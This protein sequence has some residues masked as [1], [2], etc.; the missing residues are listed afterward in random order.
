MSDTLNE[1]EANVE[2]LAIE[3]P[4]DDR[5][6]DAESGSM[7]PP[8]SL[9]SAAASPD[10]IRFV[11][12]TYKDDL[13]GYRQ[14]ILGRKPNPATVELERS[15]VENKRT[16]AG[17]GHGIGKTA[18][19]ADA[20][21]WF[22]STRPHPAIVATANTEDQLEKK[23]WRELNKTN[24]SAKNRD[25]FEWK[26]KT[27]T[28]FNDPTAQAV[29][30]TW[31]ETNPEA[32][33]GTH[34]QHVLGVFDEASAI[35]RSIFNSFAGAMTT[36]G[37][38][39]LLLGNSTRNEGYF[40]DAVHGKLKARKPGDTAAR[41]VEFVRHPVDCF[42]V[43]RSGVGRRDEAHARRGQRRVPD[44]RSRASAAHRRSAVHPARHGHGAMGRTSTCSTA[45][46]SCSAATSAAAIGRSSCRA[47]AARCWTAFR[48]CT[49]SGRWTSLSASRTKSG[50]T[51]TS[52]T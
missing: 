34:E 52:T 7:P 8:A 2:R 38:R 30:L 4:A 25:W 46:R 26:Q 27:F 14:D 15:I 41:H 23:L 42:A 17:T 31:S 44:P 18:L 3:P 39:W 43:R 10:F 51:A 16:A 35:H 40:Y 12:E 21:H 6:G 28:M 9:P 29:A 20:I 48:C 47:A 5:G 13:T 19:G 22:I 11:A 49:A 24:Q 1:L 37:A 33:A 50:S 45:G 36:P 32:F